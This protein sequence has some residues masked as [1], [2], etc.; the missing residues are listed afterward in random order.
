MRPDHS[1][2]VYAISH[3][4]AIKISV[5]PYC[6]DEISSEASVSATTRLLTLLRRATAAKCLQKLKGSN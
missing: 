6:E 5:S 4:Y 3:L 1:K 2:G